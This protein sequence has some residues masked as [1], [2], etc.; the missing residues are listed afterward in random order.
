MSWC[1]KKDY[2]NP[3]LCLRSG[4]C[5]P[6]LDAVAALLQVDRQAPDRFEHGRD[7]HAVTSGQA[8]R[9]LQ[10]LD[11]DITSEVR[12]QANWCTQMHTHGSRQLAAGSA[13][14]SAAGVVA[15]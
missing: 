2:V 6:S 1:S 13:T 11:R 7:I 8:T 15:S 3:K 9:H 12:L 10:S 4:C 14:T 5:P